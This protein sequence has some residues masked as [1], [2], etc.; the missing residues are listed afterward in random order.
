MERV[1]HQ[2]H[3]SNQAGGCC[4]CLDCNTAICQHLVRVVFGFSGRKQGYIVHIHS[5]HK[6]ISMHMILHWSR[7]EFIA[8]VISPTALSKQI[9]DQLG[10][11]VVL[12]SLHT[13]EVVCTQAHKMWNYSINIP[14]FMYTIIQG[15]LSHT[16]P[17][18]FA[19]TFIQVFGWQSLSFPMT[20][21][22]VHI[23]LKYENIALPGFVGKSLFGYIGVC[24][25]LQTFQST[26]AFNPVY[27]FR[28]AQFN[29]KPLLHKS[30][31][32]E[33]VDFFLWLSLVLCYWGS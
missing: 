6:F 1:W 32:T 5:E 9:P 14:G 4:A 29:A 13:E 12:L 22:C 8:S 19:L 2:S 27:R 10:S 17:L 33:T 30:A 18:S 20:A 31:R 3:S 15:D 28:W 24:F 25:C 23:Y 26:G 21:W 11:L 7:C 16:L